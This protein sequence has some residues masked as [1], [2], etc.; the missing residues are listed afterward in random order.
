[1]S[2]PCEHRR[3]PRRARRAQI[4]RGHAHARA[5]RTTTTARQGWFA[6]RC[7]VS[8]CRQVLLPVRLWQEEMTWR[9]D[10]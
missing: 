10:D 9:G 2:D 6:H 3:R 7:G 5:G 8:R 1:M 4:T